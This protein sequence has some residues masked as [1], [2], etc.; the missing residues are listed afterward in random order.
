ML[1]WV[2]H[3]EPDILYEM[4]LSLWTDQ[5]KNTQTLYYRSSKT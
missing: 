2:A 1:G 5:K 3:S 4:F